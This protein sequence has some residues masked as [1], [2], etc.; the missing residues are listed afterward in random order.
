MGFSLEGGS[1]SCVSTYLVLCSL[2]S[3]LVFFLVVLSTPKKLP[4]LPSLTCAYRFLSGPNAGHTFP[5]ST[6]L[7]RLVDFSVV[8]GTGLVV[9]QIK[10]LSLACECRTCNDMVAP[11]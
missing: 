2:I 11:T 10:S 6:V 7:L 4:L 5:C 1:T 3:V 9:L 8:F